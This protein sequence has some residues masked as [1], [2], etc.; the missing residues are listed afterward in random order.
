METSAKK[1]ETSEKS[2]QLVKKVAKSDKPVKTGN[3]LVKKVAIV[4]I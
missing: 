3:K 4:A 2:D 1:W